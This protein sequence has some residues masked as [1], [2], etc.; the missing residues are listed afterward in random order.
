MS[1]FNDFAKAFSAYQSPTNHATLKN[2]IESGRNKNS[3]GHDHRTNT[4]DDRT[5][6]QKRGDKKKNTNKT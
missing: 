1:F 4:G 3:G 2:V 6:A 5:P